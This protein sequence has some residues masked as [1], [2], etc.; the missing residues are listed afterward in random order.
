MSGDAGPVSS[1]SA[2]LAALKIVLCA[3]LLAL[4]AVDHDFTSSIAKHLR[5]QLPA[6]GDPEVTALV[7]SIVK[8]VDTPGEARARFGVIDGGRTEP[9]S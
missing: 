6:Y 9:F 7:E 8:H 1:P 2:E 3:V 4:D 5:A